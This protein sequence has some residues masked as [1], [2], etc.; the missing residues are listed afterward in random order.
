MAA[1]PS[2]LWRTGAYFAPPHALRRRSWHR[3]AALPVPLPSLS[4]VLGV[5]ADELVLAGF[6]I[7]RDPPTVDAWERI[8]TEVTQALADFERAGWL[9]DPRGYHLRPTIPSD[10]S[11]LSVRRWESMGLGWEQLR[12]TSDWLP[13]PDE[14][15][16]ERWAGYEHNRRGSAW[17]LRHHDDVP[18]H[19]AVL[20]HGTEQGRLLVDQAVFRARRLHVEL[21]CNVIMPLLPLHASRRTPES[22]GT[23]FP[24]LD[25]MDNVHGLAQSAY[26]VRAALAWVADQGASAISL[27][28]LS[29]GGYVAAL[30]AGLEG[31]LDAVVG[32]VPAVDFP[33]LFRRRTPRHMRNSEA[34]DALHEAS[35]RLHTVV[36]PL[37]F[38]PATPSERL[39]V[40]AGLHDRLLDPLSQA[41]RLASHW[42]TRN[43]TWLERGHVTHMMSPEFAA[44]LEVAVTAST[45]SD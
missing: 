20:V 37:S 39:H 6:K 27:T 40:L 15:G 25:V 41:G 36:S 38:T 45:R 26:D 17:L 22:V 14:A 23:G 30:V 7:T 1:V 9:A 12:W 11:A 43:V 33:D 16:G 31:P 2:A 13:R 32:L 35:R 8:A 42:G 21:G 44:V 34:F 3:N 19:W 24:T 29:L 28:G 4:G 5:L 10:I 18:R